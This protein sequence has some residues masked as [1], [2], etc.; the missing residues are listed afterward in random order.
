[1]KSTGKAR[2]LLV[3]SSLGLFVLTACSTGDP[4]RDMERVDR[5]GM[6]LRIPYQERE[7][8]REYRNIDNAAYRLRVLRPED[9][10]AGVFEVNT[11]RWVGGHNPPSRI[12]EKNRARAIAAP[13]A[14]AQCG[15]PVTLVDEELRQVDSMWMTEFMEGDFRFR[16]RAR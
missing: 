5:S 10:E 9:G 8:A 4:A 12:A 1:M 6:G 15:G 3:A 11:W 13:L 2:R 16:C 7:I 14:E